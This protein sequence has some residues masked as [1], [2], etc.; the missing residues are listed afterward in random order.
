MKAKGSAPD[1]ATTAIVE[2]LVFGNAERPP[3]FRMAKPICDEIWRAELWTLSADDLAQHYAQH[4][5]AVDG[6]A[7]AAGL[8]RPACLESI[9]RERESAARSAAW[10]RELAL[11]APAMSARSAAIRVGAN[12]LRALVQRVAS[13]EARLQALETARRGRHAD[14]TED[15][16]FL[17][18]LAGVFGA[19]PFTVADVMRAP[20]LRPVLHGAPARMVG[21]WLKRVRRFPVAPYRLHRVTRDAGG[22]VWALSVDDSGPAACMTR[23]SYSR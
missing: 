17:S 7:A 4:Q 5:A 2:W 10:R 14:P 19:G 18:A 11:M 22:T 3:G 1:V 9:E 23:P 13:H 8:S 12:V 21:A 16:R 15:A 20:E 6:L